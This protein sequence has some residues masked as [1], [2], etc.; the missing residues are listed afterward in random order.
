[1]HGW[2]K[3]QQWQSAVSVADVV[4]DVVDAAVAHAEVVLPVLESVTTLTAANQWSGTTNHSWS[5]FPDFPSEA[6]D[7][8]AVEE[9]VDGVV[10]IEEHKEQ[11]LRN[12]HIC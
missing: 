8:C 6:S 12:K 3:L 11:N 10:Y 4:V 2:I 9:E 5:Q 1:M 7:E